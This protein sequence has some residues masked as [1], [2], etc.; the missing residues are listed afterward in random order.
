MSESLITVVH[1]FICLILVGVILLQQG[2]GASIGATFGGGGNTVFGASGADNFLTRF[3]TGVA[4]LFF[5]TSV[6]LALAAK[7]KIGG[8]ESSLLKALPSA[9]T[10]VEEEKPAA[11]AVTSEKMAEQAVAPVSVAPVHD[12]VQNPAQ[13]ATQD[14]TPVPANETSE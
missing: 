13:D 8:G 1:V 12:T 11:A 14:T 7:D 6:S 4:I 2:K 10:S 5:V 9:A 3:T